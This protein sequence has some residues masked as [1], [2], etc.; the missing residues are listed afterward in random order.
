MLHVLWHEHLPNYKRIYTIFQQNNTTAQTTKN[1]TCH[2]ERVLSESKKLGLWPPSVPVLNPCDFSLQG[3]LKF[4]VI[5]L[6]QMMI[7]KKKSIQEVVPFITS[8]TMMCN[9]CFWHV[10]CMS[11]MQSKLFPT[12]SLEISRAIQ[13]TKMHGPQLTVNWNSSSDKQ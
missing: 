13:W 1:S 9:E 6:T 2:F 4:I 10:W 11:A 12:H 3:M 8:R 7:W 5:I